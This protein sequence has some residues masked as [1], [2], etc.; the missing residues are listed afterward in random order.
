MTYDPDRDARAPAD[1]NPNT[2]PH[3]REGPRFSALL[4]LGLL[5]AF[6]AAGLWFYAQSGDTT[7]TT[8][9]RFKTEPPAERTTGTGAQERPLPNTPTPPT[10]P[11]PPQQ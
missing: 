2:R 3:D 4:M 10:V 9:D 6:I 1:V 7:V 11:S 8:E 5:V